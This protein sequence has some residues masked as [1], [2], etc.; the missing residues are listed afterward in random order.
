MTFLIYKKKKKKGGHCGY[1]CLFCDRV[2]FSVLRTVVL[3]YFQWCFAHSQQSQPYFCSFALRLR[4]KL[5][6]MPL[7]YDILPLYFC[8]MTLFVDR[9]KNVHFFNLFFYF[10][11]IFIDTLWSRINAILWP[12]VVLARLTIFF[13]FPCTIFIIFLLSPYFPS[14]CHVINIYVKIFI[15]PLIWPLSLLHRHTYVP[16]L[17]SSKQA[18]SSNSLYSVQM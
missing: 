11:E 12:F 8:S 4:T 1:I 18:S 15:S 17:P 2:Q 16:F 14:T 3:Y 13:F 7:I 10:N 9:I 6:E 5:I